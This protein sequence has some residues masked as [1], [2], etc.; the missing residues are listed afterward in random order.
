MAETTAVQAPDGTWTLTITCTES[1][2]IHLIDSMVVGSLALGQTDQ[3]SASILLRTSDDLCV[4]T[5]LIQPSGSA[6]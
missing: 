3:S 5:G 4:A 6:M 2:A 1:E